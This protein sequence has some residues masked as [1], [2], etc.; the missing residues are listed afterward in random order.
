MKDDESF[1]NFIDPFLGPGQRQSFLKRCIQLTGD[2]SD[3]QYMEITLQKTIDSLQG[4]GG[5]VDK[6][7][8]FSIPWQVFSKVSMVD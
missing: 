4:N 3:K 7:I 5:A 8:Y 6:L 2:C 1:R